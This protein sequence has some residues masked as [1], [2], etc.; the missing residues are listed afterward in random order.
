MGH[1]LRGGVPSRPGTRLAKCPGMSRPVPV[2]RSRYE[3]A[4]RIVLTAVLRSPDTHEL[5]L[6]QNL[7]RALEAF[8]ARFRVPVGIALVDVPAP[9]AEANGGGAGRDVVGSWRGGAVSCDRCFQCIERD[10]RARRDTGRLLLR[11]CRVHLH[12]FDD[13]GSSP[14]GIA[15]SSFKI[16][17]LRRCSQNRGPST[18]RR[19]QKSLA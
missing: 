9:Q 14:A 4:L 6:L 19:W 3:P 2:S 17:S 1:P 18:A 5:V 8:L 12:R 7:T 15:I 16:H 11:E 10:L 13:A